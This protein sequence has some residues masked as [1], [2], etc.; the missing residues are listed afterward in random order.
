MKT[1]IFLG[2]MIIM[3]FSIANFAIGF[4]NITNVSKLNE[5]LSTAS[6]VMIAIALA[7]IIITIIFSISI[8]RF[9]M[10]LIKVLSDAM[11]ALSTGDTNTEIPEEFK[12][13]FGALYEAYT[14]VNSSIKG[15]VSDIDILTT[16]TSEGRLFQRADAEKHQG[17]YRTI[18]DGVN[19][20]MDAFVDDMDRIPTPVVRIDKEFSI[21]YINKT[22]ADVVGKTQHELIGTKCYEAF[23]TDDCGTERCACGR[24]MESAQTEQSETKAHPNG[25]TLE[26]RYTG[27]PIVEDGEVMGVVEMV[28]D[29]TEVKKAKALAEQQTET[30]KRLLIEVDTAASQ[31]AD[32]TR[33]VSD[34][35]QEISQGATEQASAIEELTSTITQVAEQTEYNAE[36]AN[37]ANELSIA[38]R[39]GAVSGNE[40]MKAMQDAME[41]INESSQ[42]I[43]KIIKVID[44]IAFQTNILALNAAVEAARAGAHGKGFAVVAEEVRNLAARSA[45]AAKETTAL[46]EGSIKNVETG[47]KIADQTAASLGGIVEGVEK[48]V[49]LVGEIAA[50]SSEQTTSIKQINNGIEQLSQVVQTNSATAE[51]GAAASEELS[52]QAEILQNMV[53]QFQGEASEPAVG[54]PRKAKK[55]SMKKEDTIDKPRIV[56]S[57]DEF[58]KY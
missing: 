31:V 9:L 14:S 43:S 53:S 55:K 42:N 49:D 2:F 30:M 8:P 36:N 32:G 11:K 46:I 5:G 25:S 17:G 52:S 22:G 34:G 23:N 51:E 27:T 38:A 16:A 4:F 56:L 15:I 37:K 41:Q 18:V 45:Q 39:D 48:A 19:N 1:K 28:T 7:G 50:A 10:K 12:K 6:L 58:G 29:L 40:Q 20:M 13:Q 47:T 24:A 35:N 57:D 44:D 54:K 21:T 26:I 3:L 33:Q